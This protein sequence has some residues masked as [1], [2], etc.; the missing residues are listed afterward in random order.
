M[1]SGESE[2]WG[3]QSERRRDIEGEGD[4][5]GVRDGTEMGK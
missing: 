5:E 4:R 1:G 3:K 2:S